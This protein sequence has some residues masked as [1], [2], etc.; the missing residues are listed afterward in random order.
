MVLVVC[1]SVVH[2]YKIG[3]LPM[4]YGGVQSLPMTFMFADANDY[5]VTMCLVGEIVGLT[6]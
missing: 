2:C 4:F 3:N 6:G 1:S 5:G